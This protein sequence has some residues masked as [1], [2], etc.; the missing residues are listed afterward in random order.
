MARVPR[1]QLDRPPEYWSGA[2]VDGRRAARKPVL[3]GRA[4]DAGVGRA[5]RRVL[6]R[7]VRRERLVRRRRRDPH[8]AGARR[9]PGPRC[10][11]TRPRRGAGSGCNNY[12]AFVLPRL[13][14]GQ[15]VIAHSNNAWDMR[16]DAFADASLYRIGVRA[17]SV[18]GVPAPEP[19]APIEAE[20]Q[21]PRSVRRPSRSSSRE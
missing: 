16:D 14:D 7:R 12:G 9:V 13:E 10:C 6:R 17:L 20:R 8:G 3:T 15:V 18:P 2:G 4:L 11:A 19:A 21:S 5:L 1:G